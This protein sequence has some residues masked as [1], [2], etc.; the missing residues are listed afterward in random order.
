M[1]NPIKPSTAESLTAVAK[2]I[3]E[4]E[5]ITEAP[6]EDY[7]RLKD[8]KHLIKRIITLKSFMF[9]HECHMSVMIEHITPARRTVI[10]NMGDVELFYAD[11]EAVSFTSDNY[12]FTVSVQ[13]EDEIE[14][15]DPTIIRPRWSRPDDIPVAAPGPWIGEE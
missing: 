1:S 10:L 7:F 5:L 13:Q 12:T 11:D 3:L 4:D 15:S 9:D 6:F 14:H 8:T 2:N